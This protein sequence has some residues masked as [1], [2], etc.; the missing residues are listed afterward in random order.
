MT[1]TKAIFYTE[2]ENEAPGVVVGFQIA[3]EIL[4]N[5]IVKVSLT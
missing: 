1:A 2:D 4:Q 5:E 3:Y